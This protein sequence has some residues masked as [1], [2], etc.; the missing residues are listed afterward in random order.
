MSDL[1]KGLPEFCR[2]LVTIKPKPG[3]DIRAEVWMP[4]TAWNGKFA[5]IGNGG[6]AGSI[7]HFLLATGMK[8]GYATAQTDTGH[9]GANA[10][11]VQNPEQFV[12]F[13]HRAIHETTV[14]AKAIAQ[15][16][17]GSRPSRSYFAG[18]STGGR[19]ALEAA[20]R[21]PSDFDAIAA[22]APS[23]DQMRLY[24]ARI[25]LNLVV[26][27]EPGSVIPKEKYSLIHDAVMQACDGLD[28]V[29]DGV[30]ENPMNCR[31]DYAQLACAGSDTNQCL[32]KGQVESARAMTS[33]VKDPL[34][35]AVLFDGHLWPGSELEWDR[36]GGTTPC[37]GCLEAMK[38]IVFPDADWDYHRMSVAADFEKAARADGG[39][40]FSGN[41]DLAPFFARGGK[42]LIYH[43]WND[44]V[45]TPQMSLTYFSN[46]IRTVGPAA[47][48]SMA[49]YM[50]PGMGHCFGGPGT[51]TFSKLE[52]LDRW[53]E[54][55]QRPTSILASHVAKGVV[56]RTH[57][58]CPFPQVAVYDKKG[59]PSDAASFMCK[60]QRTPN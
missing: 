20:Q 6:L 5:A 50:V 37:A 18:C 2:A 41:A 45:V 59:N 36:I 22:G 10:D 3:S 4:T 39:L 25:A 55:G 27:K 60:E 34:T 49:L 26:N 33:A 32:T 7:S 56:D 43:G 23:W 15:A 30:I 19:Q 58:L 16:F 11:F 40:L 28:G 42:L 12:D 52:P 17:Y 9:V 13:A 53:V 46:V 1:F 54:S 14:Q 48:D 38:K 24:A 35:G 47:E 44:P 29:K 31:F 8:S 57:P 51:D 21:Y